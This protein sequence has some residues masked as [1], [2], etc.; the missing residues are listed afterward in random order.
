MLRLWLIRLVTPSVPRLRP[1]DLRETAYAMAAG[2]GGDLEHY[3]CTSAHGVVLV[4]QRKQS[5]QFG[6]SLDHNR[7]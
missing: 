1:G 2:D 7:R 5:L 4:D 3:L 6:N